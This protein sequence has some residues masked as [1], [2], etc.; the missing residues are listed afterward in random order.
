MT[1]AA[2]RKMFIKFFRTN[3]KIVC[4]SG[5]NECK[6]IPVH[7]MIQ[8][9]KALSEIPSLEKCFKIPGMHN[10]RN[11]LGWSLGSL[12]VVRGNLVDGKVKVLN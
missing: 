5:S 11:L 2:V 10:E 4:L 7:D 8:K 6:T 12:A 3:I 9:R 1:S